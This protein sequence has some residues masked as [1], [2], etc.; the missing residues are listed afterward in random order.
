MPGLQNEL[1]PCSF[2]NSTDFNFL[3]SV[4]ADE[5]AE[6][7]E[8]FGFV[9]GSVEAVNDSTSGQAVRV[10]SQ[11]FRLRVIYTLIYDICS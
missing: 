2:Y 1:K 3:P 9:P 10:A 5:V 8:S 6:V 11:D 4:D 7:D